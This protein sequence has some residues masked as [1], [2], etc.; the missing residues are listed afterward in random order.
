MNKYRRLKNYLLF[1]KIQFKF[2]AFTLLSVG[3]TVSFVLYQ[4]SSSFNHLFDI[5]KK[6]GLSENAGY[7][8]LL[9]AQEQVI[10]KNIIIAFILGAIISVIINFVITHRALGPFYRIKVFFSQYKKGSGDEIVFR[11]SDYFKELE[12]DINKALKQ[13]E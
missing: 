3:F 7:F 8:R 4:V 10:L 6:I 11:Q 2:I 1:P 9:K 12:S 5:G 13:E